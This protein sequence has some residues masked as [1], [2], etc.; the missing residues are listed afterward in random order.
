LIKDQSKTKTAVITG[1]T[2]FIGSHLARTLVDRGWIV[3]AIKRTTSAMDL[4]ADIS[5]KVQWHDLDVISL[6]TVWNSIDSAD[7]VY[8]L[9]TQYGRGNQLASEVVNTNLIFPMQLLE[10]SENHNVPLFVATDTCFPSSYPYLRSYTL[11]KKQ[12]A[13]WGKVWAEK[14]N[15]KF[16]NVVLQHPYGPGDGPGK[17]VPWIIGQCQNNV[18]QIELTSGKQRKDFIFIDDVI[19]A[20]VVLETNQ[21]QLSSNFS[22]IPCGSGEAVSLRHFV[23]TVH[24]ISESSS[25]LKFGVLPSREGELEHS[26]ADT[27]RLRELGWQPKTS[28]DDGIRSTLQATCTATTKT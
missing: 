16:V 15:R 21:A 5:E 8:H 2:G 10:Q 24:S 20:L 14:T 23:E 3:H 22:E 26:Y 6:E 13:Q 7:V 9:A 27:E 28:L 4:V 11:S 18:P 17:F 12:F 19:E 1:A 25:H